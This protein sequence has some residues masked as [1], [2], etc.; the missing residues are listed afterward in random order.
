ME[1][2]G[3]LIYVK[4]IIKERWHGLHKMG[5]AKFQ[6]THDVFQAIYSQQVGGF[7]TG[8]TSEDEER[9]GKRLG[10]DLKNHKP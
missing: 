3:H 4:P 2:E 1:K 5:R 9:L 8:L 6:G 7:N 10:H